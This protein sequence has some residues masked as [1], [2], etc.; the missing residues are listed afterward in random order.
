MKLI[1]SL[2]VIAILF[3]ACKKN[4]EVEPLPVNSITIDQDGLLLSIDDT[5]KLQVK[6]SCQDTCS[7]T[8]KSNDESIVKVDQEGNIY[9]L[10]IGDAFVVASTQNSEPDTC[11]ITVLSYKQ[12][13]NEDGL[14]DDYVRFIKVDKNNVWFSSFSNGAIKYDGT[15][16]QT[17]DVTN[18]LLSN[19]ITF[20]Y[21]ETNTN[22]IWFASTDA[23]VSL[24]DGTQWKHFSDSDGLLSNRVNVVKKDN[25]GN[26]W[27]GTDK[28][29]SKYDGTNWE[30]FT[31][32]NNMYGFSHNSSIF[33]IEIDKNNCLYFLNHNAITTLKDGIWSGFETEGT[34]YSLTIDDN[35]N[36]WACGLGGFYKLKDL[37]WEE[38]FPDKEENKFV[39]MVVDSKN[40]LWIKSYYYLFKYSNGILFE[41]YGKINDEV[42]HSD[43]N[44]IAIDNNDNIWLSKSN[45]GVFYIETK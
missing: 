20:V 5:V 14:F 4:P 33:D 8:W 22:N 3:S 12:F 30:S 7:I 28:G 10:S 15:N 27:F 2:A 17:Y 23:G 34:T 18:G 1:T 42:I 24:Y 26:M 44:E 21:P 9:S 43:G 6:T 45:E 29:V 39:N 31:T 40:D 19:N 32:E 13:T 41:S 16:W 25:E 11:F 35:N 38:Q 36:M 37:I